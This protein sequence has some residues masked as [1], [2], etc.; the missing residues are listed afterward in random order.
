V[1]PDNRHIAAVARRGGKEVFLLNGKEVSVHDQINTYTDLTVSLDYA[2][3]GTVTSAHTKVAAFSQE[4]G[5]VAFAVRDGKSEAVV[6]DGKTGPAFASVFLPVFSRDGKRFAYQASPDGKKQLLVVDDLPTDLYDEIVEGPLFSPDGKHLAYRAALSDQYSVVAD[7]VRGRSYSHPGGRSSITFSPDGRRLVYEANRNGR[8]FLVEGSTEIPGEGYVSWITFSPDSTRL[9][10]AQDNTLIVDGSTVGTFEQVD[11]ILFSADS[12]HFVAAVVKSGHRFLVRDGATQ[13]VG[14]DWMD[15]TTL[16]VSPDGHRV[17]YAALRGDRRVA[18]ADGLAPQPTADSVGPFVFTSDSKRLA[19]V[20]RS[21]AKDRVVADGVIGPESDAVALLTFTPDGKDLL[22]ASS[23]GG[24]WR[25]LAA[26]R[27]ILRCDAL[28]PGAR[29]VFE[30]P[31]SFRTGC[32][33]KGTFYLIRV[34]L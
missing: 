27:E 12:K 20:T 24:A 7:G 4:G 16:V 11:R 19:F 9:A 28:P 26:G 5:R 6:I 14:G 10:Y 30:G 34:P 1:S 21:G 13:P 32:Q 3:S 18:V 33:R 29:L 22:Y 25:I 15:S 17:A 23:T 31:R 2:F 8:R